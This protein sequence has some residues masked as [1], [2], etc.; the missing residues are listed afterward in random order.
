M[1]ISIE[2]ATIYLAVLILAGG[3]VLQLWLILRREGR[4]RSAA[5]AAAGSGIAGTPGRDGAVSRVEGFSSPLRTAAAVLIV[6]HLVLLSVRRGFPAITAQYEALV[7]FAGLILVVVQIARRVRSVP[8]LAAIVDLLALLL[9]V[10]SSSPLVPYA[11]VPPMPALRSGWMIVHIVLAFLGEAFFT[12][13]F[14]ASI[15]FLLSSSPEKRARLDRITYISIA[16]GYVLFTLGAL[17]FGAIWAHRTWGR[18]WGWDPKETWSLIT[19]LIY[20]VYLHL[21]FVRK[22]SPRVSAITSIAGYLAMLFTLFG[23]N[24]LYSSIHAY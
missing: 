23:V 22:R 11:V 18:Y 9:L 17:V 10:I 3:L 21:R 7:L 16:Y 24:W 15:L 13:A 14:G 5:A 4:A 12:V 1:S 19:W 20:S 6:V 2:R 8:A